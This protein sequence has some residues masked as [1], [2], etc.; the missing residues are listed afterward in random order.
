MTS[1][2][3]TRPLFGPAVTVA[4]VPYRDDL[5]QTETG[6]AGLFYE[7]IGQTSSGRALVLSSGDYPDASHGGG[8]KLSRVGHHHLDGVL[9][10]RRAARW[11]GTL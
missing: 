7:A 3:P 11:V 2:D 8:T 9:A 1:P 4:Y 10:D 6:F 5:P